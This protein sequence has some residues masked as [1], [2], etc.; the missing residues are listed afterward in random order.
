MRSPDHN[1]AAGSPPS[2]PRWF[3][4][5][6]ASQKKTFWACF[7]GWGLDAMDTQMYALSIPTL[8]MLWGMS[9]GQAGLLGTIVL[10]MA[11]LGG[12]F[13]GILAD[14]FGR[15]RV[16]QAT[17]LWFSAF[18]FLAG[19]THSFGELLV[20]R[21]LQ[22]LGFGGEW[23]VGSVLI[24]EAIGPKVR[25]R[26]V[27]AIQAGWAVGYAI[28]VLLSTLLFSL[29]PPDIAWRVFFFIG[30]GPGLFVLWIRRNIADPPIFQRVRATNDRA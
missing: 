4:E 25:G 28:A 20:A 6:G 18:T 5:L 14:R 21:S 29:L 2:M 15:V 13:A 16:L 23:A 8:I 30:A 26:V 17:I 24:S 7:S 3:S 22:G 9:K 12:W 11:A 1:Q 10:M 27:G 19:F